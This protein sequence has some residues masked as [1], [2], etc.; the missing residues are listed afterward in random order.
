LNNTDGDW[1]AGVFFAG[2]VL[3]VLLIVALSDR[4]VARPIYLASA[5]L[6]VLATLLFAQVKGYAAALAL[7]VVP[8]IG[9]AGT[10]MPGLKALTYRLHGDRRAR[11]VAWYTVSFTVGAG[12]SFVLAGNVA[13]VGGWPLPPPPA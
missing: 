6:S 2:Y 9:L 4:L 7:R 12:L 1:L 13:A 10:H 11:V 3:S 5:A 8:G